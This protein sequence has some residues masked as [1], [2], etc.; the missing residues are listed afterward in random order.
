MKHLWINIIDVETFTLLAQPNPA[1]HRFF[2]KKGIGKIIKDHNGKFFILFAFD[3]IKD[4][5]KGFFFS[6]YTTYIGSVTKVKEP[7]HM[8]TLAVLI[9]GTTMVTVVN[10]PYRAKSAEE[11]DKV[12]AKLNAS[13][14]EWSIIKGK[15]EYPK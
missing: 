14:E 11:L 1:F 4:Q 5:P 2:K 8:L 9:P 6:K 15:V 13:V 7:M 12:A 10:Y 3:G